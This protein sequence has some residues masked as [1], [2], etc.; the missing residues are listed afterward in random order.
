MRL[1]RAGHVAQLTDEDPSRMLP[2]EASMA[3]LAATE[4]AK[5][6][7]LEG[8]QSMGGYGYASEYPMERYLRAAVMPDHL[9]RNLG[10]SRKTSSRRRSGCRPAAAPLRP[11][12]SGDRR[13]LARASRPLRP[14]PRGRSNASAHQPAGPA[15]ERA[16]GQ[17]GRHVGAAPA[18]QE[19]EDGAA[20]QH[21]VARGR[22]GTRA[23]RP[24]ACGARSR[25]GRAGSARRARRPPP[26]RARPSARSWRKCDDRERGRE[27]RVVGAEHQ[28][29]VLVARA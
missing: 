8:M 9:R 28:V 19:R 27:V 12:P 7:A 13:R 20:E 3:K 17:R 16:R 6:C 5:K 26:R 15:L 23:A 2:K 25:P 11:T 1:L 18:L 29:R 24:R 21:R 22:A 14:P 4:L 10:Y